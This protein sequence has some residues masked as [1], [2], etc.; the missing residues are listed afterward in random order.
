MYR[1]IA[2]LFGLLV[3]GCA[4]VAAVLPALAAGP[5]PEAT[6]AGSGPVVVEADPFTREAPGLRPGQIEITTISTRPTLVTGDDVRIE[7]RGLQADDV[8]TVTN[9]GDFVTPEYFDTDKPGVKQIVLTE[10]TPGP[11]DLVATASGDTYGT[12]QATL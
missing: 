2:V 11:H 4:A 8:L 9:D 7:V 3:C 1:L 12:R 10:L 5:L 6:T